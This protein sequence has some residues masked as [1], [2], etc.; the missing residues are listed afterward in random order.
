MTSSDDKGADVGPV[1]EATLMRFVDGDLPPREH[2]FVA[3][4]IA[5]HPDASRS[6]LAYRFTK[7]N[8][9]LRGAY[10]VAMNVPAELINRCLA[11]A[12]RPSLRSRR[13]GWRPTLLALAASLALL[14]A[15][16][17]GWILREA[18]QSDDAAFLGIAPLTHAKKERV[19]TPDWRTKVWSR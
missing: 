10:D 13:P 2:A 12:D 1:F 17:A 11:A 8:D 15:G 18:T 16:A 9:E 6:V 19:T 4:L 5:A 14:L 7:T 3:R